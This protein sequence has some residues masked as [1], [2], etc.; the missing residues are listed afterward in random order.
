MDRT[1]YSRGS[2]PSG[3]GAISES[4]IGHERLK[5]QYLNY[6]DLK[7]EEIREQQD[8]RRYY[9][10]SQWTAAQI[11]AFNDRKQPVVTYNREGRKINA[12]VGL[13]ARQRRDPKGF[14]RTEGHE[15]GAELATHVLRYV[16][17]T[18]RWERK[19]PACGLNAAI[20][21]IGGLEFDLQPGDSGR[22]DDMDVS[23]EPVD[24]AS[25]F[26][27]PRSLRDDFSDARY[28]GIGK[29]ADIDTAV[30]MFPEH[31]AELRASIDGD[32]DLTSNP[33]S[34]VKWYDNNDGSHRVR[35]VDHWYI[36][37]G[38]WHWSV[39]TGSIELASGVSPYLDEK[40]RTMCKFVMF[41]ANVDH[42]GDRYG[43]HRNMKSSQDEINQ[44]RSKGL[45]ILNSR[46]M[47]IEDGQG[48]NVEEVRKEAARPDGVIK[49]PAGTK[50][51]QFDDLAKSA[52]LQGQVAFL[53][54]A[55]QEIENF[56]FNPALIGTGVDNMSGKAIQLQQAAGVAELGPFMLAYRD[57]KLRV[58][59]FVWNT[60]QRHW[61]GER[62]VR[63]TDDEEVAQFF[64][65]NQLTVDPMTGMPA[66]VNAI[67]SLDVDIILDEGPDTI[68]MQMDAY[69]TLSVM[70]SKGAQVPPEVLIELSPLQ[71][72]VKKKVLDMIQQ[73]RQ[74]Q[75]PVMQLEMAGKQAEV[76]ETE[77][78][79]QLKQAQAMKAMS[80][81]QGVDPREK[82]ID[83]AQ[84]EREG[85]IRLAGMEL[86]ANADARASEMEL[87]GKE[88]DLMGKEMDLARLAMT[89]EPQPAP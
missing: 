61:T 4:G 11:K 70:A 56:G 63:V 18:Q 57:W 28:M 38:E 37:R 47:V 51:P 22:P 58:Y 59:R 65:V 14:P 54:D 23:F 40:G 20:D 36:S 71:G 27:D 24:P 85:Q 12:V 29:W 79:A 42:D 9:H 73:A 17:D 72:R 3:T 82:L 43:F 67:G 39:Y 16:M 2:A 31:E 15:Q 77:A 6:I 87:A 13:L 41:S 68:N 1:G 80:E 62:W 84:R 78:S 46:R 10:G 8:A 25:F 83:M 35:L 49:H 66:L 30:E 21:G 60:V 69:D 64:A 89:P 26:Y 52:E 86:K 44:R 19:D 76:A 5:K 34:D 53:E 32:T 48:L 7:K 50:A 88:M 33:D 81:A 45:H 55:K 74:A 75:A